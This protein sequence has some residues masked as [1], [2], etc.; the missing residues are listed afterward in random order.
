MVK[1]LKRLFGPSTT[2]RLLDQ[3]DL[4]TR[5]AAEDRRAF[6]DM[7]LDQQALAEKQHES[8]VKLVTDLSSTV[9]Q[10]AASFNRWLDMITPKGEPA[11]RPMT[12]EREAELERAWMAEHP[13][14]A[15]PEIIPSSLL[16]QLAVA[17]RIGHDLSAFLSEVNTSEV[18]N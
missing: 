17:D 3:L 10:H 12:D 6:R 14:T 18:S 8:T 11:V 5:L 16:D 7:L 1:W 4:H 15:D 2:T 13:P 9:T